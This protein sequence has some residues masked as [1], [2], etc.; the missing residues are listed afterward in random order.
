M[1]DFR[2]ESWREKQTWAR[3]V[4]E[5]AVAALANRNITGHYVETNEEAVAVAKEL[6]T[7]GCKVAYG[8]S[9]SL[10]ESGI[11]AMIK[12][13]EYH[14]EEWD[15]PDA[16]LE[17]MI[18][19]FLNGF[20]ADVFF[21]GVNAMTDDGIIVNMCSTGNRIAPIFFGP[22]KVVLLAG[23]NKLVPDLD[24]A[25]ARAHQ[26]SV[27]NNI[28]YAETMKTPC[29]QTGRCSNCQ[30][31]HRGCAYTQIIENNIYPGRIHVIIVGQSLGY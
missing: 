18:P 14:V 13:G 1:S 28:K 10:Y 8:D 6:L 5:R 15:T 9:A 26:G 12:S 2:K 4:G 3:I 20:T 25:F 30:G 27:I 24:A 22:K 23:I 19:L 31:R 11:L 29:V 17:T 16:T 7:P 21:S